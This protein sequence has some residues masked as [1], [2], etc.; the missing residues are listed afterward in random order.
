MPKV[1]VF[2]VSVFQC[3]GKKNAAGCSTCQASNEL[4]LGLGLH[5]SWT[6]QGGPHSADIPFPA[7]AAALGICD[8]SK[9][10]K[11]T[12]TAQRCPGALLPESLKVSHACLQHHPSQGKTTSLHSP[13]RSS[14]SHYTYHFSLICSILDFPKRSIVHPLSA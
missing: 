2:P 10:I 13:Y 7:P 6:L 12:P 5:S 3:P 14:F 4:Q 9:V 8:D 11:R 1:A